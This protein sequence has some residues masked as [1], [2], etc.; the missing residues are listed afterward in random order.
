MM[1]NWNTVAHEME[2]DGRAMVEARYQEA[3]RYRLVKSAV[4]RHPGISGRASLR[5]GVTTVVGG[6]L[7]WLRVTR[8]EA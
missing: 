4:T 7:A 3:E 8:A 5:R 6:V 2:R 1:I